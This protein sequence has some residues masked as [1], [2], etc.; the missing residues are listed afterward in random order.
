MQM[1]VV[2]FF[3]TLEQVREA[4]LMELIEWLAAYGIKRYVS[5]LEGD[6]LQACP[7][8]N[9]LMKFITEKCKLATMKTV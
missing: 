2:I 5:G 4:V 8:G 7:K 6:K 9:I 1:E 3:Y